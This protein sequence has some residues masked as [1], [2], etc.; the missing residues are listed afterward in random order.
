MDQFNWFKNDIK[1]LK[2]VSPETK[3]SFAYHIPQE[4]FL[5]AFEKYT[6][7]H[8]ST[9]YID[10]LTDKED[11]DF[12]YIGEGSG[13]WD[14]SY[15][16]WEDMKAMGCDS[17]FVGHEHCNSASIVY[18]GV[19]FQFGQKSSEYDYHN[20]VDENGLVVG[21]Y[22]QVGLSM[23][24]GSVISLSKE[25][26]SIKGGYVYLCGNV[27]EKINATAYTGMNE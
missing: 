8:G 6:I 7:T 26:G 9:I 13:F 4:I 2:Q 18:D 5:K 24:G 23:I 20:R 21:G 10:Y 15:M 22:A 14:K 19:R 27:E 25:D 3:I 16:I 12:G 1:A 17:V 11:G